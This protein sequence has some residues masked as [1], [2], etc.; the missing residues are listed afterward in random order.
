MGP[1]AEELPG[2]YEHLDSLD[3]AIRQSIESR[4]DAWANSSAHKSPL[5]Q[6]ATNI[7]QDCFIPR[8]MA[9]RLCELCAQSLSDSEMT[10]AYTDCC[11]SFRLCGGAYSLPLEDTLI[12]RVSDRP[13]YLAYLTKNH[14]EEFSWDEKEIDAFLAELEATPNAHADRRSRLGV[15]WANT[16]ATFSDADIPEDPFAFSPAL[17]PAHIRAS[18]GLRPSAGVAMVVFWY[19]LPFGMELV[20]PTVADAGLFPE[21]R[22]SRSRRQRH[23]QT[24]P[25]LMQGCK[26]DTKPCVAISRPE[27]VHRK[28]TLTTLEKLTTIW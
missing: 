23:G 8:P 14:F 2:Y 19:W 17:C 10:S 4:L 25:T 7:R 3:E 21:F 27:G 15:S 22:P 1:E 5:A 26:H 11:E 16:W 13:S 24:E 28:G 6:I 9:A 12:G 18:L 20:R